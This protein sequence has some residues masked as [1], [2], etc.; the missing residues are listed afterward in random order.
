MKR[1]FALLSAAFLLLS[2]TAC[3]QWEEPQDDFLEIMS[4]YYE[5]E[6]IHR[7]LLTLQ[8]A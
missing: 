5:K 8:S 3:G 1:L 2:L 7:R 6:Q 4:Q